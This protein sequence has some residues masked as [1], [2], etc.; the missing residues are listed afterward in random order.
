MDQD[1]DERRRQLAENAR[2]RLA[3]GRWPQ[4]VGVFQYENPK[5]PQTTPEEFA[6]LQALF[7]QAG[8]V[9][10]ATFLEH[11]QFKEKELGV[12]LSF[13]LSMAYRLT[14]EEEQRMD[15]FQNILG[16]P[17]M[18]VG[19]RRGVEG[20]AVWLKNFS[21]AMVTAVPENVQLVDKVFGEA[22][23]LLQN[24]SVSLSLGEMLDFA[25]G[26]A[27]LAKPKEPSKH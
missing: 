8:H 3:N 15:S 2:K 26:R 10:M 6:R 23:V 12:S 19:T 4:V 16:C 22:L 5:A 21:E 1:E 20:A 24:P 17:D 9:N 27:D 18:L 7:T 11:L 25:M 13:N 14:P